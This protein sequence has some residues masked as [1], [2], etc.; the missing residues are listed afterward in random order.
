M[1]ILVA[2]SSPLA[3][4]L[5]NHI[6]NSDHQL[7]G[8]ISS[9][10]RASGRGQSVS[11]N[12]FASYCQEIGV[13]CY[14]PSTNK[15]LADIL[16]KTQVELVIT[17][18][19]GRLIKTSELQIPKHGWLN[20]HFSLLPRW[21][22]AAPVQRAI[23]AGDEQSGVTVF[24]LEQG[25]DTGPI[26]STLSYPL[27]DRS[28]SDEVLKDLSSLC[29]QPVNQ[30]LIMIAAG[31]PATTQESEGVMLAP[32]ILKSEG[33]ID[34]NRDSKMLDRQIRAFQPWPGAYTSLNGTRIEIIEARVSETAGAAGE[35][36]SVNP[37]LVGTGSG[38]LEI[39]RVKPENKRE[40]S[41]SDWLRGA[42]ITLPCAFE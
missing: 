7:L 32:K 19:Y 34:W 38:S 27:N 16:Q 1:K 14:K 13:T 4:D 10:D 17:L 26:Y 3:K 22:G 28:R 21:R 11:S 20:V 15:E 39:I 25:L 37:L 35:V 2:S 9:P 40:M 12:D 18:A 6:K 33:R 5:L 23:A 41:S 36:I 8:G 42:R 24:K 31:E 29:I 30:A